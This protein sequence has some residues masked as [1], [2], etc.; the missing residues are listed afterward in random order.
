MSVK[1]NRNVFLAYVAEAICLKNLEQ[2]L[3]VAAKSEEEPI[4]PDCL[5][6]IVWPHR[7]R[8]MRSA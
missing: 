7:V 8:P 4:S 5:S 3:D 1:D 2:A 6:P